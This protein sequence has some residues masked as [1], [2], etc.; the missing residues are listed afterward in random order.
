MAETNCNRSQSPNEVVRVVIVE[1]YDLNAEFWRLA[2]A[3]PRFGIKVLRA[4]SDP[5]RA[6]DAIARMRPEVALVAARI[7]E[8]PL[9]GF[10]LAL[11]ID[12][13]GTITQTVLLLDTDD[14]GLIVD[15]FRHGAAGTISRT[16]CL[17]AI[18][19]NPGQNASA[20][21]IAAVLRSVGHGELTFVANGI[22]H[23]RRDPRNLHARER[24][25]R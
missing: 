22:L 23:H 20:E 11:Q 16:Q 14:E 6:L 19:T 2:L 8:D 24:V 5:Q 12:A 15:A 13:L 10:G 1:S 25:G 21:F 3:S 7:G 4:T 18:R 17:D 9:G